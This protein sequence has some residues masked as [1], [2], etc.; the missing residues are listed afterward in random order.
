M[1]QAPFLRALLCGLKRLGDLVHSS[2]IIIVAILLWVS[3]LESN[4]ITPFNPSPSWIS[5]SKFCSNRVL[6]LKSPRQKRVTQLDDMSR[7]THSQRTVCCTPMG[8][9]LKSKASIWKV[10]E[11]NVPY[12]LDKLTSQKD[13]MDEF[14]MTSKRERPASS[15]S[16]VVPKY[17]VE[18][19]ILLLIET[20]SFVD[21]ERFKAVGLGCRH[22]P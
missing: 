18:T 20:H 16:A 6:V 1:T 7:Q 2:S 14:S 3:D 17:L 9:K 13:G 5:D 15:L 21:E 4:S 11:G 19:L 8:P 22:F 10:N 12:T